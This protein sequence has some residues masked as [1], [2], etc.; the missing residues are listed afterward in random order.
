MMRSDPV[1][2]YAK[3]LNTV[4]RLYTQDLRIRNVSKVEQQ[5]YTTLIPAPGRQ[6]Q[7]Q[8]DL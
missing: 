5:W 2:L 3:N 8:M 6:R 7:R 1:Q 4:S